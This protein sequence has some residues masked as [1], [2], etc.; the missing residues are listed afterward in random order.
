[1]SWPTDD[2]A[3]ACPWVG[4]TR[5]YSLV[6]EILVVLPVVT[7]IV[8]VLAVLFSS[9]DKPATTFEQWATHAPRDFVATAASELAGT[10]N[11]KGRAPAGV[12]I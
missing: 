12:R 3:A 9:P 7:A 8:L 2:E 1:M 4:P 5:P 10:S 6:K 11:D